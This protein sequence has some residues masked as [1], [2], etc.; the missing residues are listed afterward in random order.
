[1]KTIRICTAAAAAV[2]LM[3]LAQVSRASGNECSAARK[4]KSFTG[5]VTAVDPQD[6]TFSVKGLF[7]TR[8]FSMAADGRVFLE[9]KPGA[10]L[11]ELRPGQRVLVHYEN[12]NGVLIAMGVSQHDLTYTGRITAIDPAARTLA[13]RDGLM[14]HDLA[15]APDCAVVLKGDQAGTWGNLLIGDTVQVCYE[16]A[17]SSH[18]ARR[19]QEQ[20]AMFVGTIQAVDATT[21][22]IK[23][24]AAHGEKQFHLADSCPIVINGRL[25]G[26]MSDL[27][28]GDRV[29]LSYDERDGVLVANRVSPM[30]GAIA[31]EPAAPAPAQSAKTTPQQPNT[32]YGY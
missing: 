30:T 18:I 1:M 14:T 6:K 31:A 15:I 11:A 4:E 12:D 24:E 9:N 29:S 19:I 16:Q 23:V 20:S 25:N 10:S 26:G 27:R 28:I 32:F 13:L 7:F 2:A 21:K 3:S 5:N 8:N 22:S 17:G